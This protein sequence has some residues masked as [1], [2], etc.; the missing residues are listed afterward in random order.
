MKK[1][2]NKWWIW[3]IASVVFL[4]IVQIL[5]STPAPF[6]WLIAVWNAGDLIS[7]VG[8]M[9][10]GYVAIS[11]TEWANKISERLL[12]LENNKYKLDIR[13]F[14]L[15]TD[16]KAYELNQEQLLIDSNKLYVQ[17]EKHTNT[18]PLLGL[19]LNLTNTTNSYLTLEYLQA[20]SQRVSWT[21]S[22]TNQPNKKL[23]L[24]PGESKEIVFYA[25]QEYMMSLIS[26]FIK[27]EFI[28]ENRFAEKY[29]ES[30]DLIILKL[31]KECIHK[32]GEWYCTANAQNY[33]INKLFK[34]STGQDI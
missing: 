15:L 14:V 22:T 11:Q 17:I 21:N 4:L 29:Q 12:D 27:I 3:L 18:T 5:Y 8:T 23:Y 2:L 7:F 1:M 24:S 20:Y 33:Q 6:K 16:W 26:E 10:L 32:E 13:P 9:V 25:S 34:E 31:S 28:T 30:F 19:G